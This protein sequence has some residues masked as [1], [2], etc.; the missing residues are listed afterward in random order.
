MGSLERLGK[1]QSTGEINTKALD[2]KGPQKKE[3]DRQDI[4]CK[5]VAA[6]CSNR[7]GGGCS[8]LLFP[9]VLWLLPLHA[10]PF[11]PAH[12]IAQASSGNQI[13]N[14]TLRNVQFPYHQHSS[15]LTP[16]DDGSLS[17][18]VRLTFR[19]RNCFF[20]ILAHPVYKM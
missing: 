9:R 4:K 3:I 16:T 18:W 12:K 5:Q 1:V 19:R 2:V 7:T 14:C 17:V 20:L 8:H 10:T 13:T 15:P 11:P 6:L